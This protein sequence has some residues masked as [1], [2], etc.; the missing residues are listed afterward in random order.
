MSGHHISTFLRPFAPRALP[1]L[2]ATMNALTPARPDL[3][4]QTSE[5]EHRPFHLTGLPASRNWPLQ[6]FRPQPP[7]RPLMSL[8]HTTPQRVR[9]PVFAGSGFAIT[10][11]ARQAITAESGSFVLRTGCSTPAAPHPASRRRSCSRL[12]AGT[13]LPEGD[14]HPSDHV[15]LQA[16]H[17]GLKPHAKSAK[18][19][20][21]G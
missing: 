18:P 16:H 11:Q 4:F 20:E 8:S 7:S 10:W 21:A 15:R 12:L 6:P 5:H 2:D 3:R 13:C 14:F 19:A 17:V 9:H 1:R